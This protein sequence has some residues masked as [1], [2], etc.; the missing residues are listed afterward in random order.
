VE[1]AF[2][3]TPGLHTW[4]M[5]GSV[6]TIDGLEQELLNCQR[7]HAELW[8]RQI[9]ALR[10]LDWGQVDLVD[11]SRSMVEWVASRLDVTHQ[12]ARDLVFLSKAADR[13]VEELLASGEIGLD[14]A[15][16]MVRLRRAGASSEV[17]SQSFGFDL[18]GIA[19]L[20]AG[21]KRLT[22]DEETER[23]EERY[24]ILQSSLD[25]SALKYWGQAMGEECQAIEKALTQ[26]ADEFPSVPGVDRRQKMADAFASICIDSLTGS[27]EGR[28]VT[29]AEVFVDATLAAP[30]YGEAGITL[31]SGTRVGPNTLSEILCTGKVRV[32]V[33]AADGRAIG[34]SDLGEAIPPAVRALVWNRD[35]GA[36][37]I[38]GCQ[39]RYRLEPHHIIERIGGGD[40]DPNNLTL[41]CWYH[42]HVAIHMLGMKLDPASPP[43]RRRL[44]GWRPTTGPPE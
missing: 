32:I 41:L 23:F 21:F 20:T 34:V 27:S 31:S 37:T 39:S 18:G 19:K 43:Q 1:R 13:Q 17:I 42:H 15:V 3:V 28:A 44:I 4:M 14:R 5:L 16:A 40:H 6:G 11:G 2:S 35:Q 36:C 25:E 10:H 24:L 22:A 29:V 12:Q 30:T 26:R 38:E 33:T 8:S 7:G 9:E